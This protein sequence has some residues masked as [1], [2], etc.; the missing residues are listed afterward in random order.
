VAK[1]GLDWMTAPPAIS[2][3]TRGV[4]IVAMPGGWVADRVLGA[5]TAVFW[6]GSLI[7]LGHVILAIAGSS[8]VFMVGLG[9][10]VLGT[11]LLKPNISA[12]VGQLY[13]EGGGRRD[14]AFTLFY[15]AINIGGALG[16]LATAWLAQRYG[17]HVGFLA[18][19][20]GMACGLAYYW[21]ARA[22][23]GAA[24]RGPG[25]DSEGARRRDWLYLWAGVAV[26]AASPCC[27]GPGRCAF[28]RLL[29]RA[30][31]STWS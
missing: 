10:I 30:A 26:L 7:T 3:C 20:I 22:R 31:R 6:G 4:Y 18:A 23:L 13:P 8:G 15:M 19:A 17:W 21:R 24:G 1:G 5:Q 11:G 29:C 2:A 12:L 16:P 14:A 9:V 25:G 27:C 28:L